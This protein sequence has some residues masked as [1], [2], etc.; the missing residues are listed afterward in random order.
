[1]VLK[2]KGLIYFAIMDCPKTWFESKFATLPKCVDKI[3]EEELT[4]NFSLN[5]K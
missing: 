5:F 4:D 1:M 3:I 2:I